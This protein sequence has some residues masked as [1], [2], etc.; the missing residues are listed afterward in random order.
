MEA[1]TLIRLASVAGEP[2][3]LVLPPSPVLTT[4]VTPA[5]TAAS[6]ASRVTSST[7][8]GKLLDP[9]DSLITFAPCW[10]AYWMAW[11]KT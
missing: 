11:R 5:A 7:V 8:S 2:I 3:V 4:T 9:K 1:P 10:T 6:S